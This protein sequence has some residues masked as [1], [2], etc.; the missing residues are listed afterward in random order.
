VAGK[1]RHLLLLGD[2][3]QVRGRGGIM[4]GRTHWWRN[5][6]SLVVA[7]MCLFGCAQAPHV[8]R[9]SSEPSGAM[10]F[11]NDKMIGE[12]PM[13]TVIEQRAGDYNFYSF[14]VVK[15]DYLPARRSFK[16]QRY[17]QTVV[18]LVPPVLHFV[19]EE[20][21]KYPIRISSEPSGALVTLNGEVI[22]ETP[23]VLTLRERIGN[24][25]IFDF[26]AVKEGY[27][28]GQ[29]VLK[30]FLPQDNGSVFVFPETLHFDLLKE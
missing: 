10:V 11:Y 14:R 3:E 7:G 16:E 8:V 30:E 23:F 4:V 19:L 29:T 25:R 28:K 1:A 22:G 12:T 9:I 5:V 17:S 21:K 2:L 6:I 27:T 24:P 13:E 18:D 26:I 15:E 20:R